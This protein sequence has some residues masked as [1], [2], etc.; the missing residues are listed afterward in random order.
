MYRCNI[1]SVNMRRMNAAMHALL[2]TNEEDDLLCVQEPWFHRIGVQR[3]DK[4]KHGKDVSGGA[5]HPDFTL[6]YPYYTNDRIAKVMTYA[7][8]YARTGKGRRTTPI[9]T[10]PRLDLS[11]HP[12]LRTRQRCSAAR[13]EPLP[14]H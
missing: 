11:A 1:L 6:I 5:A 10:I 12:M 13:L 7:R 3:N 14:Q 2:S 8:K 4:V 9:R